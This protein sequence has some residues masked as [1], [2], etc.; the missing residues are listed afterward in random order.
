MQRNVLR[1][2][3]YLNQVHTFSMSFQ[4]QY[5]SY[6]EE[7]LEMTADTKAKLDTIDLDSLVKLYDKT[8]LVEARC[9]P[10]EAPGK[11]EL[12]HGT[13]TGGSLPVGKLEATVKV[14]EAGSSQ[15]LEEY[16]RYM[17]V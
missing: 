11:S 15:K 3:I 2:V 4:S 1:T 6:L 17:Y 7:L 14:L 16:K 12:I 8:F 13:T 10:Q 9:Q 5:E